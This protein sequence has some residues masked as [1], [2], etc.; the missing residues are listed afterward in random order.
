MP[1]APITACDV[2]A[3]TLFIDL[4][5]TGKVMN[6]TTGLVATG[7]AVAAALGACF[8]A[9][10]WIAR[11]RT[12]RTAEQIAR[13]LSRGEACLK[14]TRELR[15]KLDRYKLSKVR[16]DLGALSVLGEAAADLIQEYRVSR[17]EN[18]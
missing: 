5:Q 13:A 8:E 15:D 2:L 16:V 11:Q 7:F 3:C 6:E 1:F 18:R 14:W 17:L 10:R 4:L 12:L 9:F